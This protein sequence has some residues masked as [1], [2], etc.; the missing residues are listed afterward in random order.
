[1][2]VS[3]SAFHLEDKLFI[4]SKGKKL[5]KLCKLL[6]KIFSENF[7]KVEHTYDPAIFL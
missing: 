4:L 3:F 6:W 7:Y 1:M 5:C 2:V